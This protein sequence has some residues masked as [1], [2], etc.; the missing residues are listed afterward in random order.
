[1]T[2]RSVPTGSRAAR[3]RIREQLPTSTLL[4]GGIVSEDAP[5][6]DQL[7]PLYQVPFPR[8][9]VFFD[10]TAFVRVVPRFAARAALLAATAWRI[11]LAFGD[12][13]ARALEARP[14]AICRPPFPRGGAAGVMDDS[15]CDT[16]AQADGSWALHLHGIIRISWHGTHST[17]RNQ[18]LTYSGSEPTC[19]THG[20]TVMPITPARFRSRFRC[21]NMTYRV[22]NAPRRGRLL[23]GISSR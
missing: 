22:R 12:R 23:F 21:R 2:P 10:Q 1:M 3:R 4:F 18:G 19:A 13:K 15:P 20:P 6:L 9:L 17:M 11:G 7:G 14:V 16:W 5:L 8:P